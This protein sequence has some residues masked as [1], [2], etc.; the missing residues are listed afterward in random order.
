LLDHAAYRRYRNRVPVAFED[1]GIRADWL[2]SIRAI[3]VP[4]GNAASRKRIPMSYADLKEL[5]Y[6][7][8]VE[9]ASRGPGW[10]QERPV[11][12]EISH[13]IS[14]GSDHKT[15]QLILTCWHDLFREGRL[16]WGYDVDNPN[17]PFFHLPPSD[18][19]REKVAIR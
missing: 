8:A 2:L 3:A 19:E 10:S 14:N 12:N 7:T 16:S 6:K 9:S 17:A 1:K 15:Q 13:L 4:V 18:K 5:V 11:L